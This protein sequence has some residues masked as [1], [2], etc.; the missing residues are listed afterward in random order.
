MKKILV[1]AFEFPPIRASNDRTYHFCRYLPQFGWEPIV[2]APQGQSRWLPPFDPHI[3]VPSNI[4]VH[5]APAM[6]HLECLAGITFLRVYLNNILFLYSSYRTGS[7]ILAQQAKDIECIYASIPIAACVLSAYFLSIR[8]NKPL[9]LD[10]R[11]PHSPSFVYRQPF[12]NAIQKA[13][14]II[15]TTEV[16]RDNLIAQGA[17]PKKTVVIPN[18]TDVSMIEEIKKNAPPRSDTFTVIYA[19]G[20][21]HTYRVDVLVKK[22][23][24]HFKGRPVKFVI[25]GKPD[26]GQEDL[27]SFATSNQ[28]NVE[29]KGR[30]SQDATMKE[31]LKATLAYNGSA[32]PGGLGGKMYDYLACGLPILGF[33]PISSATHMFITKNQVG[34]T[35]DQEDELIGHL[36]SLMNDP[37]AMERFRARGAAVIRSF[38]RKNLAQNLS[39]VL[40]TLN[41]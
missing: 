28:L 32:H 23:A 41:P 21:F 19:G 14:R 17:D 34:V 9:V 30:L 8:F 35:T 27:E 22:V 18:G 29:F 2:V 5:N 33:N 26:E 24:L 6:R 40:N 11:D 13:K 1:I 7:R 4:Q 3:T 10:F 38:D 36:E 12:H 31:M 39:D 25:V 37:S 16:Y 15:T 20:Y